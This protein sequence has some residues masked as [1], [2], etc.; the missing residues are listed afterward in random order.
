M[1]FGTYVAYEDLREPMYYAEHIDKPIQRSRQA[2]RAPT[3]NT[4]LTMFPVLRAARGDETRSLY[5]RT[6]DRRAF[7]DQV[8]RQA[9]FA[10]QGSFARGQ[11]IFTYAQSCRA[12]SILRDSNLSN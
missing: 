3:Q 12:L 8:D 5:A 4:F 1:L 9:L 6:F 7:D 10:T 11:R 2:T